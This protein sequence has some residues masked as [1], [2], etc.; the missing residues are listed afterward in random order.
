ME[1][2]SKARNWAIVVSGPRELA[3]GTCYVAVVTANIARK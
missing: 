2:P 1:E 3:D